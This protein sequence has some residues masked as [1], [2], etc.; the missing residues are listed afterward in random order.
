MAQVLITLEKPWAG[1]KDGR[2]R[3]KMGSEPCEILED[4]DFV[5][6]ES[7][8]KIAGMK[9]AKI[10]PGKPIYQ[11][12]DANDPENC[13]SLIPE[14]WAKLYFGDWD[15]IE[16]R[17]EEGTAM[18]RLKVDGRTTWLPAAIKPEE[19]DR[20]ATQFGGYMTKNE[21][22]LKE[23]QID[24]TPIGPPNVPHVRIEKV[25]NKGQVVPG[26]CYRPHE[27]FAWSEDFPD[28]KPFDAKKN[29][30]KVVLSY[31]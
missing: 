8:I 15:C 10:R 24:H 12:F 1:S 6:T 27:F 26:F 7:A 16:S 4:G 2:Y 20:V 18:R 28:F 11:I 29:P 30:P 9:R 21:R 23:D 3:M 19:K 31:A 5:V 14:E 25:D 17:S 13:S 22:G